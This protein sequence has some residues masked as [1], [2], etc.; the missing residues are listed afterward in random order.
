MMGKM[1][2]GLMLLGTLLLGITLIPGCVTLGPPFQKIEKIPEDQ[3]LVY[4]YRP[5][6]GFGGAVS[7]DVKANGI[8][9]TTLHNGGY[10]PHFAKPGEI[11]FLAQTES[12]SSVTINV[13]AGQTYYLKGTVGIGFF[14]GRPHLTVVPAEVG[15]KEI[16][17][18]KLI[19]EEKEGLGKK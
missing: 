13:K 5:S 7:Y 4:L 9:V 8:V 1:K 15:E 10:Y 2:I 19:P 16:A 14:V 12:K 11:E 6:K 17:E 3:G 18:C